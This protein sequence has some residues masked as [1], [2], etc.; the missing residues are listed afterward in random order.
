LFR[1]RKGIIFAVLRKK[2]GVEK[3][4][5]KKLKNICTIKNKLYFCTRNQENE[6]AKKNRKDK[7]ID[8]LD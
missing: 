4:F 2:K 3:I 1:I 8:I 7:F 6:I 5:K